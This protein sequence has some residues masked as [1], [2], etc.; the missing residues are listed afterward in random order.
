VAEIVRHAAHSIRHQRTQQFRAVSSL[1]AKYRWCLTGT[2]I[3]NSLDDLSALVRFLR[4]PLIDIPAT[5]RCYISQP[6]ESGDAKGF[7]NLRLLLKVIC[8][9]RTNHIIQLPEPT[10]IL[11]LQ[12]LSDAEEDVY[13]RIGQMCRQEIDKAVSG[14]A[15]TQ[16]YGGIM[17]VILRLRLLCN[18]GTYETLQDNQGKQL[19]EQDEAIALLQQ[20]N[21]VFCASC[22][23]EFA[24][25]VEETKFDSGARTICS[26][27][28]CGDC[29]PQYLSDLENAREGNKYQCPICFNL[30]D[31]SF[32]LP[33]KDKGERLA[34]SCSATTPIVHNV[35][36]KKGYSTKLSALM[37]DIQKYRYLEKW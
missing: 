8:L 21:Q 2:P 34:D 17:Q 18:H 19:S 29:I 23:C 32:L 16:G 26:H 7:S 35:D 37:E 12:D 5:F 31:R 10:T 6:I 36:T 22:S 9:R 25:L 28:L 20:S 27:A 13:S 24:S 30:I 3:Q 11:R 14:R 1:S 15:T 33:K 4:V